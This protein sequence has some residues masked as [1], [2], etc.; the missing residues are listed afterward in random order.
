MPA[1]TTPGAVTRIDRTA[2][3]NVVRARLFGGIL[4]QAQVD[5]MNAILDEWESRGL[6]D[7][8]WLAYMLATA[9]HETN[10]TMQAVREAYWLSEDW[11]R[12]HLRYWPYYGRGLVQ[13]TW[14]ENYEKMGRFLDLPLV[15]DPDLALDPS[16]SVKIMFEGMLNAETG[17]GDFTGKSLEMYF[18]DTTDDPIGAR[19]I[20]NGTDKAP[21]IAGYHHDFLEALKASSSCV[22]AA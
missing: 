5:G 20:I 11:R 19:K 10:A 15:S 14:R 3:F 12:A 17:V 22:R 21:L 18:N 16:A 9:K 1:S 4:K 2:F 7:Q 6:K 8:R 13:L